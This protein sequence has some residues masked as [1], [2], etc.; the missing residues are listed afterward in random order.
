MRSRETIG[1]ITLM[2]DQMAIDIV[3]AED[4]KYY[5]DAITSRSG[6]TVQEWTEGPFDTETKAGVSLQWQFAVH[7]HESL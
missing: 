4:G 7:V 1:P 2:G 6:G 3:P 5:V